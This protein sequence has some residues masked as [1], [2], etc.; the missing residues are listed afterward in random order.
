SAAA[1]AGTCTSVAASSRAESR[2]AL[3]ALMHRSRSVAAACLLSHA[4]SVASQLSFDTDLDLE[5]GLDT[6]SRRAQP[7][8]QATTV[9]APPQPQPLSHQQKQQPTQQR[10][11]HWQQELGPDASTEGR[12]PAHD[13]SV[14]DR[15]SVFTTRNG[16]SRN[17]AEAGSHVSDSLEGGGGREGRESGFDADGS[18][19][20]HR[21][22]SIKAASPFQEA[23][24]GDMPPLYLFGSSA[25]ATASAL[26]PAGGQSTWG[27]ASQRVIAG[28]PELL[29]R[30]GAAERLS[31]PALCTA[32]APAPAPIGDKD[33]PQADK[34]A[35]G[36]RVEKD[37]NQVEGS[38]R[39]QAIVDRGGTGG[40]AAGPDVGVV[41]GPKCGSGAGVRVLERPKGVV[42]LVHG[43]G[44][45]LC[46]D[47]LRTE[48]PGSMPRYDG[49]WVEHLNRQG[50]AVCGIDL[51]GAGRSEGRR[52]YIEK[53]DH[54][55]QDVIDFTL[56][57]QRREQHQNQNQHQEQQQQRRQRKTAG[58]AGQQHHH[59]SPSRL[60][61]QG[62]AL[63]GHQ[64]LH[65]TLPH[66]IELSDG[67]SHAGLS[68]KVSKPHRDG[69]S[70][71]S[72]GDD[73][74]GGDKRGG[75]T[76]G[77]DA[78]VPGFPADPEVAPRFIMGLSLGGGI[79]THIML[80]TGT[81]VFSGT[82]LLSPMISL[83][84]MASR[85]PNRLLRLVAAALNV[86]YPHLPLVRG[87]PNKVFPL[88]QQ[89]WDSDPSCFKQGTRVRNALE[90][91]RACQQLCA[92]LHLTDFPFLVFHS[93]RDKWTD[94]HG[95]RALFEQSRS[96]DKTLVAV[97]HMFHVL[98]KEDGWWDVLTE[99]VRWLD[100][101]A[102]GSGVHSVS[103]TYSSRHQ[104]Q[105]Q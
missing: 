1:A 12:P 103:V 43:H 50:Y 61:D 54:Y 5:A 18:A 3:S 62:P 72:R 7:R 69:G 93:S 100:A 6:G 30:R 37:A 31:A 70:D 46:W 91:L 66:T 40:A 36:D 49:S 34:T 27:S 71:E 59:Q 25:T 74:I 83:Q 86:L 44:A 88:I 55:V 51:Q 80:H 33:T 16:M 21:D 8:D 81:S 97:D 105:E 104:E 95:S 48:C 24:P 4:F 101:H 92:E 98:T 35:C 78:I 68:G 53:F 52:C 17:A 76:S 19:R 10:W 11:P 87:E 85:G 23:A 15:N 9:I 60:P 84:G 65:P 90:Y 26:A 89:L 20:V 67:D 58:A 42:V 56:T 29:C 39:Q 47:F 63:Q 32:P 82:V 102:S 13:L 96:P 73:E 57:L 38:Q 14:A 45:Y 99:A 28:S 75:T 94:A 64:G 22:L 79:A 2:P 41:E 77:V